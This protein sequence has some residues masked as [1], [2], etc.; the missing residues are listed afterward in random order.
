MSD[1]TTTTIL[2]RQ[3]RDAADRLLRRAAVSGFVGA[4]IIVATS[5]VRAQA[6]PTWR[7]T[8]PLL[9]SVDGRLFSLAT[10]VLGVALLGYGWW[11]LG[12]Y[13]ARAR[14]RDPH[15]LRKVCLVTALWSGPVLLGPPLLSNDVYSYA[16]HG[17][18]ASH[19]YDVTKWG[20]IALG[21]GP[22]LNAAD[23]VWHHNPSPYGPVW[24][25]LAAAVVT[26]TDH[27]P[28]AAVWGFRVVIALS[29]VA[30]TWALAVLA[31]ELGADPAMAVAL[32]IANPLTVIHVLGGIHN[33]GLM[34]ALLLI[35]LYLARRK[36]RW[37]A[38]VLIT[39]ATA[40]KLPA[41]AGLVYLGWNWRDE[42]DTRLKRF[43]G[44]VVA[45]AVGMLLIVWL[46]IEVRMGMGWLGALRGTS[47][48]MSTFAPVTMLGL[49]LGKFLELFG[50]NVGSDPIVGLLRVGGLLLAGWLAWL[51]LSNCRRIGTE[52]ALGLTLVLAVVLGPVMWPWYLPPAIAVL[53]AAGAERFRPALTVISC[54]VMLAVVPTSARVDVGWAEYH[55]VFRL[56]AVIGVLAG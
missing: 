42:L 20:P 17:E 25:K 52:R 43:A 54:A 27:D 46:S 34:M 21:G 3:Q 8:L 1:T 50:I 10:F 5:P 33:D 9:S 15:R 14:D 36:R 56:I 28:A 24:N 18:L 7:L 45:G 53:V 29:V 2:V 13:V 16:A 47:K 4:L 22:F 31:A 35:G 49:V 12:S 41:A 30:A 6:A 39:A 48:V 23:S 38:L 37:A 55:S 26:Q 11:R 32:A 19:G 40:V 51:L 44:A